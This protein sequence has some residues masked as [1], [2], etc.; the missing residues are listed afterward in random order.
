MAFWRRAELEA[1][2]YE[3]VEA[4]REGRR[5]LRPHDRDGLLAVVG[6]SSPQSLYRW[7]FSPKRGFTEGIE[8]FVDVDFMNHMALVAASEE[9]G[10]GASSSAAAATS[11]LSLERQR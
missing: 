10:R 6:R 3:A 4:L 8:R 7:F 1:A 5:L 9:R 2:K 11:L